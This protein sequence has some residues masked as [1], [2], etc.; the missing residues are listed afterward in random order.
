MDT[1]YK[2]KLSGKD[3][4]LEL[5]ARQPNL[6]LAEFH[7]WLPAF[8]KSKAKKPLAEEAASQSDT[9][10]S[11]V[12]QEAST[13][14]TLTE[15]PTLES[16]EKPSPPFPEPFKG[17]PE[18]AEQPL[19]AEASQPVKAQPE[20]ATPLPAA[21]VDEAPPPSP[22]T[23][24]VQQQEVDNAQLLASESQSKPSSSSAVTPSEP[25]N[26]V[27]AFVPSQE[28]TS[29][30]S[31]PEPE[32]PHLVENEP[33]PPR[34][35][36]TVAPSV[37]DNKPKQE[38]D[39]FFETLLDDLNSETPVNTSP[40]IVSKPAMTLDSPPPA[41]P[42]QPSPAAMEETPQ[43]GDLF[44]NTSEAPQENLA[45]VEPE[46][47]QATEE[48][49][50]AVETGP[51]NYRD[52]LE[53]TQASSME[54]ALAVGAY[55]LTIYQGQPSFSL[56]QLNA[57]GA[58]VGLNSFT[59]G[60]LEQILERDWLAMVPDET[61]LMETTLYKLAPSGKHYVSHLMSA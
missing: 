46:D 30:S 60:M 39:A 50:A 7:A 24:E 25:T 40:E 57:L 8:V 34:P 6:I 23:P 48:E 54:E 47:E 26:S 41:S 3:W 37:P 49:P 45:T 20:E 33:A 59:H 17:S 28:N 13:S 4:A 53:R 56:A 35:A 15:T 18:S 55:F 29:V 44:E 61:G 19:T 9:Q 31:T 1:Y 5:K 58:D 43:Q 11:E 12:K 10:V 22:P 27:E 14:P 36:E 42:S 2:I 16:L 38:A 21:V 52:L 51:P 32:A